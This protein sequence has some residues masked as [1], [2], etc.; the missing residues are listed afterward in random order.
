MPLLRRIS[1]VLRSTGEADGSAGPGNVP[2]FLVLLAI[3]GL[4]GGL[5]GCG[6]GAAGTPVG[7]VVSPTGV[8]FPPGTPP[9]ETRFS[10]TATLYLRADEPE[11]ALEQALAGIEADPANPI[12]HFLAGVAGARV[13]DYARADR[14]F[15]EAEARYPAYALQVEPEREAAWA[16]AFNRGAEAY[17]E[18]RVEEAREAWA[19]S[20]ILHDL[21]PEAHR[22][23]ALLLT[24]EGESAEA[25]A[26]YRRAL[27]GLNR[28]PVTRTLSLDEEAHREQQRDE[29]E[30]SLVELLLLTGSYAEAEELLRGRM[31]RRGDS[32][33]PALRQNLA[34]ALEG[35]GRDGEAGE[36]YESLLGRDGLEEAQRFNLGVRLFRT[37]NPTRAAEAFRALVEARPHSRDLWFNYLNALFAAEE[38]ERLVEVGEEGKSVDPLNETVRLI[39]AR[40][41]L[42]LGDE[43]A[44]LAGL[45]GVD[46]LPVLLEGLTLR[47][48]GG[49]VRVE[50]RMVGN[51]AAPG[52]PVELQFEFFGPEGEGTTREIRLE[53]PAPHEAQGFEVEVEGAADA[54]RY[55]LLMPRTP[56]A[57]APPPRR[58]APGWGHPGDRR[59]WRSPRPRPSDPARRHG[60]RGGGP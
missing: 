56:P 4:V 37:G 39:L 20:V 44:A 49:G 50:G 8:V 34:M 36:I 52:D 30:D 53:A 29:L 27:D 51:A 13:G 19:G 14:H 40:A 18:G 57:P 15:L 24:G 55:R 31:A 25:A 26:L 58:R 3:G 54:F 60:H 32:H 10:Q 17:A 23:L 59:P 46:A 22:N 16:Q 48:V 2:T 1:V 47:S 45:E 38:W 5:V 21:R 35:Q 42:E 11:R 33:D 6:A 9:V 43:A 28:V 7:P 12:H 41:H